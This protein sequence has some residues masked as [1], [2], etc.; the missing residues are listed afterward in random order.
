[1]SEFIDAKTKDAK[2]RG[3]N[4]NQQSPDGSN[5][6]KECVELS[7]V[8]NVPLFIR[9]FADCTIRIVFAYPSESPLARKQKPRENSPVKNACKMGE[10]SKRR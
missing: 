1:V 9:L 3:K 6:S 10:E 7:F 2:Q 5:I 8:H 4:V